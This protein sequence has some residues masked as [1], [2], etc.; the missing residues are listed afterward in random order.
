MS[1]EIYKKGGENILLVETTVTNINQYSKEELL[2]EKEQL[3]KRMKGIDILLS[4][5]AEVG[6][7]TKEENLEKVK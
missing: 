6:V 4:K 5:C 2:F 1:E 3:E 7:L